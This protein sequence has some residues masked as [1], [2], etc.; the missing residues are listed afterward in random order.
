[1]ILVVILSVISSSD[2][3]VS[4]AYFYPEE[5]RSESVLVSTLDCTPDSVQASISFDSHVLVLLQTLRKIYYVAPLG[6]PN[7]EAKVLTLD[8]QPDDKL[9]LLQLQYPEYCQLADILEL[10]FL[11]HISY[12]RT[13]H[14]NDDAMVQEAIQ[15]STNRHL[16]PWTLSILTGS[17]DSATI[18]STVLEDM[19]RPKTQTSEREESGSWRIL[20][21]NSVLV[22]L[23][24][25]K[26]KLVPFPCNSF[27]KALLNL[28]QETIKHMIIDEDEEGMFLATATSVSIL[29]PSGSFI[30]C[31]PLESPP[32]SMRICYVNGGTKALVVHLNSGELIVLSSSG[33]ILLRLPFGCARS[34]IQ[35]FINARDVLLLARPTHTFRGK[36]AFNWL[37]HPTLEYWTFIPLGNLSAATKLI[38]SNLPFSKT[39]AEAGKSGGDIRSKSSAVLASVPTSSGIDSLVVALEGRMAISRNSLDMMKQR[40]EAKRQILARAV[41]LLSSLSTSSLTP[42]LS[43]TGSLES[44]VSEFGLT[45]IVGAP[46]PQNL[47]PPLSSNLETPTLTFFD[48][49]TFSCVF[50]EGHYVFQMSITNVHPSQA[51]TIRNLVA[52]TP[53]SHLQV[54][55]VRSYTL[56]P[57]Q[58]AI[59]SGSVHIHLESIL[60]PKLDVFFS[61]ELELL[62]AKSGRKLL[63]LPLGSIVLDAQEPNP[64]PFLVCP[65]T[66]SVIASSPRASVVNAIRALLSSRLKEVTYSANAEAA[67]ASFHQN[68]SLASGSTGFGSYGVGEGMVVNTFAQGGM[69]CLELGAYDPIHLARFIQM[70]HREIPSLELQESPLTASWVAKCAAVV[71]CLKEEIQS[72]ISLAQYLDGPEDEKKAYL[73]WKAS[74]LECQ[75]RTDRSMAEML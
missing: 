5:M 30:S 41:F 53:E 75:A 43:H 9:S 55:L 11:I 65:Y 25:N 63:L 28:P 72:A 39:P 56:S 6:T 64:K 36:T 49:G 3:A 12:S 58:S 60:P 23:R 20:N 21:S 4:I 61:I 68:Q 44:F 46:K 18:L 67:V 50:V 69:V 66:A 17:L 37:S 27:S 62:D 70:L 40:L 15:S 26:D 19:K 8:L 71:Q 54:S 32:L 74:F 14:K 51:Y 33:S 73:K 48:V 34:I 2:V 7:L 13:T 52:K 38:S 47:Q 10:P 57:G 24:S 22:S 42:G 1:M 29:S 35:A 16:D 31:T 45:P 59:V